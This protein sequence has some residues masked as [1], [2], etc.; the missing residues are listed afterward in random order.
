[1]S[2]QLMDDL[3]TKYSFNIRKFMVQTQEFQILTSPQVAQTA[4]PHYFAL[5]GMMSY[6]S[7]HEASENVYKMFSL[8]ICVYLTTL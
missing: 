7:K 6:F 3:K 4:K 1:M 5:I 8:F 2:R